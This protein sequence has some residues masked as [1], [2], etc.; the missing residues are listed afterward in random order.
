MVMKLRRDQGHQTK[1]GSTFRPMVH[2]SSFKTPI[3]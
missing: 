3:F 1:N 2:L